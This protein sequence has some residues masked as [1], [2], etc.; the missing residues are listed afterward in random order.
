MTEAVSGNRSFAVD[1]SSSRERNS[2]PIEQI[3]RF[4]TE[5]KENVAETVGRQADFSTSRAEALSRQAEQLEERAQR[6]LE[7]KGLGRNLDITV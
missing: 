3:E 7:S 2:N 6:R 1:Y 5:R 4:R